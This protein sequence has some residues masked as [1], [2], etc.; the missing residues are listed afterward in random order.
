[1]ASTQELWLQDAMRNQESE[2]QQVAAARRTSL[3]H[4]QRTQKSEV[5]EKHIAEMEFVKAP[6]D[7]WC[8]RADQQSAS[9]HSAEKQR[10]RCA[11]KAG[12]AAAAAAAARRLFDS[13][14][15]KFDWLV[16][17]FGGTRTMLAAKCGA[18]GGVVMISDF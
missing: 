12:A 3:T 5:L 2:V 10:E 8:A 16:K 18:C 4:S 17:A 13:N 11:T 7:D 15:V 6:R 1:M 14:T 9:Q